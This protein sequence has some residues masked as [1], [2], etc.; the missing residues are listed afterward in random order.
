MSTQR[1][2]AVVVGEA[3]VDVVTRADG[4]SADYAGGSPFNVAYG[5]GRLEHEVHLLTRM[6]DDPYGSL[7]RG[8]LAQA[9]VHLVPGAVDEGRT[10]IAHARLDAEGRASYEFEL[11]WSVPAVELPDEVDVVHTGSIA[12]A[13]QPGAGEVLDLL[14]ARRASATTSFDP[15]IRPAFFADPAAANV[16]VEAFVD[17]A[18]VV[19]VSDEDLEWLRP[20]VPDHE[21][22]REWL[23]RGPALVMVTRGPEGAFALSRAGEVEVPAP[24]TD[25]VDTVGAGDAGMSGLLHALAV[26]DLLGA[27]RREAL[28]AIDVATLRDV[29]TTSVRSASIT[30]ERAGANPPTRAELG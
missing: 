7:L 17:V 19:K 4:S 28:R 26:R 6:G 10:A 13:V 2:V 15:N 21:V 14:T 29:V 22:A 30:C 3:L 23:A 18:D 27:G 1:S 8:H 20:G 16:A 11:E 25:V 12:T 24:P 9:D 5:L